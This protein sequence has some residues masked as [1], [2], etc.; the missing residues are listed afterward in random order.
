MLTILSVLTILIVGEDVEYP[1]DS[2]MI[3]LYNY[4]GKLAISYKVKPVTLT[5]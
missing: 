3:N 1:I 5:V 2:G 4:F